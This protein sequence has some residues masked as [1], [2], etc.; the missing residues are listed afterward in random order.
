MKKL[1]CLFFSL[2]LIFAFAAC[3]DDTTADLSE[4][5][6]AE[7]TLE[8]E[9]DNPADEDE[10][11]AE[12]DADADAD[13]DS[14]DY[15][16]ADKGEDSTYASDSDVSYNSNYNYEAASTDS[17]LT[18]DSTSAVASSTDTTETDSTSTVASSSTGTTTTTD[19]TGTTG[20]TGTTASTDTTGTTTATAS[21]DS[22]LSTNQSSTG[23]YTVTYHANTS[24]F[25]SGVDV[26]S[27]VTG[28][29]TDNTQYSS[30]DSSVYVMG[31]N[32]VS[33]ATVP[34][35]YGTMIDG[36]PTWSGHTFSGWSTTASSTIAQYQ[37]G[38]TLTLTAS[39][40]L[41]A[42]WTVASVSETTT[43]TT[44]TTP[45]TGENDTLFLYVILAF[46][47]LIGIVY[48]LIDQKRAGRKL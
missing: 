3:G 37:P 23:V 6:T 32:T 20:T 34:T 25:N 7:D 44:T 27:T 1:L 21:S 19:T 29:P 2:M 47:A 45:Q 8:G 40:D 43:T 39:M 24:S 10:I 4:T 46:F 11:D 15:A 30:T 36:T 48:L 5:L 33:S 41:Y 28:I 38:T 13:A 12:A 18:T 22:D 17:N 14:D 35:H 16:S 42:V 31:N 9:T 26:D